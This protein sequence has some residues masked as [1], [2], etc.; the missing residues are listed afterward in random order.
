MDTHD[1]FLQIEIFNFI[2]NQKY[3]TS[4]IVSFEQLL[5]I[6]SNPFFHSPEKCIHY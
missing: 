3:N 2:T 1:L 4:T 6:S 5:L